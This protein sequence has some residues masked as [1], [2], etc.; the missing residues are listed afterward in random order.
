MEMHLHN[1]E[2]R[3]RRGTAEGGGHVGVAAA[4]MKGGKER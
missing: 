4:N 3:V 2:R 1:T